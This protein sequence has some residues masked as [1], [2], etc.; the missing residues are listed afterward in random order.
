M[1]VDQGEAHHLKRYASYPRVGLLLEKEAGTDERDLQIV[2]S[3]HCRTA[4]NFKTRL[5]FS[6]TT[7]TS[8]DELASRITSPVGAPLPLPGRLTATSG[9]TVTPPRRL[10]LFNGSP[11]G[12]KGNTPFFLRKI[13]EALRAAGLSCN[14]IAALRDLARHAQDGR[15]P[16][17]ADCRALD[18]EALIA[19]L[20][21]IRG[22]GRWT[23][24]MFL[25]FTLGRPDVLPAGDFGVRKGYA[26]AYSQPEMP[27]PKALALAGERWAPHRS[28]AALYLWRVADGGK[29]W[30]EHA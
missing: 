21:D 7:E 1:E 5:E 10:T 2:T 17:L 15:L 14:K 8:A 23:V 18:D 3:I 24:E 27:V 4:L 12:R 25:I 28:L 9:V 22:I 11:R 20:S 19:R 26:I 30:K 16:T 6:L 29:A 13:V